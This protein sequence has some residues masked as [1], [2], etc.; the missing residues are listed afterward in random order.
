MRLFKLIIIQIVILSYSS[1]CSTLDSDSVAQTP[2]EPDLD[3]N[4][5]DCILIRTIRDYT[6]LDRQHLL[7][8]GAGRRAYFVKLSRPAFDLRGS[9]GMQVVSRDERL[10]PFGGDGLV[11]GGL[12]RQ[13]Y[14]VQSISR[15]TADQ[16]EYLLE[17]YGLKETGEQQAPAPPGEVKG[18]EVEEL[19]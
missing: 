1:A 7:V 12:D 18:A 6:A 2:A 5:S 13:Q 17:R 4:G 3:F 11:F 8:Y 19:G 16:E 14:R 15:L 10:C 9:I